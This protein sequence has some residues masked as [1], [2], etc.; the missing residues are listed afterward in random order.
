MIGNYL[1][2]S[3][4]RHFIYFYFNL[5]IA[6]FCSSFFGNIKTNSSACGLSKQIKS[7]A[8]N[9]RAPGLKKLKALHSSD[10]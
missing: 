3:L 9:T 4:L 8:T 2:D 6:Y 5:I 7:K 10:K 1:L